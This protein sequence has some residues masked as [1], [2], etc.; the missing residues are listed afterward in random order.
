VSVEQPPTEPMMTFTSSLD[1]S[2]AS[3]PSTYAQL[4][5]SATSATIISSCTGVCSTESLSPVRATVR[6]ALAVQSG[7][8]S[9]LRTSGHQQLVSAWEL[10]AALEVK[11]CSCIEPHSSAPA[12]SIAG[13]QRSCCPY[14]LQEGGRAK[15]LVVCTCAGCVHLFTC[16]PGWTLSPL[17]DAFTSAGCVH[18]SAVRPLRGCAPPCRAVPHPCNCGCQH[19]HLAFSVLHSPVEA[20]CRLGGN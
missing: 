2:S 1:A 10:C 4:S 20:A 11:S 13:A 15:L 12:E 8:A 3:T 18:L 7:R 19:V 14:V 17:L 6:S 9:L 5:G 16:S